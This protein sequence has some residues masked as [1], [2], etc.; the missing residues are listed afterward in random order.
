MVG[1]NDRDWLHRRYP[2]LAA[3]SERAW[4]ALRVEATYNAETGRFLVLGA[5]VQNTVGGVAL[6]GD[7]SIEIRHRRD[8]TLS[9][10]PALRVKGVEPIPGKAFQPDR[11]DSLPLQPA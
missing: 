10:L 1:E 7:F 4:G 8:R 9:R 3:E 5:G 2:G 11:Q 6:S